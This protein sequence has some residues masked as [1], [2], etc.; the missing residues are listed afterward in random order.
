MGKGIRKIVDKVQQLAFGQGRVKIE[1]LEREGRRLRILKEIAD[2]RPYDLGNGV[3]LAW[4]RFC[5]A[6]RLAPHKGTCFRLRAF[7]EVHE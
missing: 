1:Q 2:A 3:E 5:G 7:R 4:C 6:D